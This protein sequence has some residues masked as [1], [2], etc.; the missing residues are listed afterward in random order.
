MANLSNT[1]PW[2]QAGQGL[3][4]AIQNVGAIQD[5]QRSNEQA[6]RA[7]VIQNMQIQE[8]LR[9]NQPVGVD[10]LLAPF[11]DREMSKQVMLNYLSPY[12]QKDPSGKMIIRQGD[13]PEALK[14]MNTPQG[15]KDAALAGLADI[16]T[17]IEALQPPKDANGQPIVENPMD[18]TLREQQIKQLTNKKRNL[19][20]M[21]EKVTGKIT[22]MADKAGVVHW[23]D[24]NKEFIPDLEGM[25]PVSATHPTPHIEKVLNPDGT[26]VYKNVLEGAT[27]PSLGVV[28]PVGGEIKIGT[29]RQVQKGDQNITEEY[30]ATG[31][32]EIGRGSKFRP[33]KPTKEPGS[34]DLKRL[35][36]M[37]TS[38][39]QDGKEPTA[40]EI[41]LIKT[42]AAKSGYDF[43]NIKGTTP[44]MLWGTNPTSTWNLVPKTTSAT[45]GAIKGK[46]G[47]G[48]ILDQT[49][50][51][52]G[53]TYKYIGNDQWEPL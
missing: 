27:A 47:F 22:P 17:K 46:D 40:N 16:G 39:T 32:K 23:F 6:Q 30:S 33:E 11:K 24:E 48:Y 31:W 19:E 45:G 53:K 10:E 18:K 37:I 28:P 9:H 41:E 35:G 44:G 50:V 34:I 36:D 25:T 52:N 2:I 43:V 38:A 20:K 14:P 51:K 21:Y 8:S 15:R 1:S 7:G 4:Q 26:V 3:T 12:M 49:T 13:I 5:I 29:T 42:E